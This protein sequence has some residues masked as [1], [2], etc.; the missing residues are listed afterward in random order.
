MRSR[1]RPSADIGIV[2]NSNESMAISQALDLIQADNLINNND[3]VVITP[4][5]VQMK[6]P[7]TG[8]VVGQN[9]LRE[10][11]R[12]VKKNNPHRI[13][14]ATGSGERS[15]LEIIKAIGFDE[16]IRSE[17]VEFIDL[18]TGPFTRIS[19]NHDSP[20]ETNLNKIYNEMTFHISFAQ[21]KQHKEATMT[22][23]IKNIALS[24][25]P[26]E[27]HGHPKMNKGIHIKLHDFIRAMAESIPV[28]LSILS[29]NPA[30]I[31]T[32]PSGGVPKHT[33]LVLCSTDP[34]S[35]DTIG[36]HFLGFKQQAINYLDQCINLNLGIGDINQMNIKGLSLLD[37]EKTFSNAA[38][39]Q[40][41]VIDK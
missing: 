32:G 16:I 37:A 13:V 25:P 29:A 22:A 38:Y 17:G 15:T 19:L 10:V 40:E 8:V 35:I 31:G 34:V 30:M 4:N 3:V 24:W 28:D 9:S 20:A 21:L 27:E 36:A 2:K 39:G 18:N 41:V 33:E 11:I 7:E 12:F 1:R 14:V 6:G 23:C 26:A 5:W